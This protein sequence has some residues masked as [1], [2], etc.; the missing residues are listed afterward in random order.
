M[1][2]IPCIGGV[3]LKLLNAR[4][5]LETIKRFPAGKA[6]GFAEKARLYT[7]FP[8]FIC[9]LPARV[10]RHIPRNGRDGLDRAETMQG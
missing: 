7:P 2:R 5:V 8:S 6:K 10:S 3:S 1:N 4:Y 9:K